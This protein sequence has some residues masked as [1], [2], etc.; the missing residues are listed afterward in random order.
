M[1][2]FILLPP[3]VIWGSVTL[4]IKAENLVNQLKMGFGILHLKF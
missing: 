3:D 4:Y 1:T 2:I